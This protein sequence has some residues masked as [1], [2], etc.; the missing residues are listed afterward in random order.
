MSCS[1]E[2]GEGGDTPPPPP[3]PEPPKLTTLI[4]PANQTELSLIHI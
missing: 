2:S 3:P 4:A 1:G